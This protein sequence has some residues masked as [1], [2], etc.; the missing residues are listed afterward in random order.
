MDT[1]KS[2]FLGLGIALIGGFI[3][4]QVFTPGDA[5]STRSP[6]VAGVV[7]PTPAPTSASGSM[8]GHV[9]A[10]A[11]T[12]TT[13]PAPAAVVDYAP[14]FSLTSLEGKQ[15]ALS[16]Y[17]GD[18]SV[19]LDFFATWCHNCQRAMPELSRMYDKYEGQIEVIGVNLKEKQSTVQGFVDSRDINFPIVMD[20]SGVASRDYGVRY[21]NTH[22][23]IGR[24]GAIVKTVSGDLRESDLLALINS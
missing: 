4:Y 24:D 18:K 2:L 10:P 12:L 20:P 19:V 22:V 7:A 17:R 3:A 14:D 6:Q 13:I 21:T 5:S 16:D 11:P 9:A 23:L 15:I 8:G 1:K